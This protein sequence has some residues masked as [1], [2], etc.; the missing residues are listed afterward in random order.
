[1]ERNVVLGVFGFDIIDP[2]AHEAPLYEELIV[3]KVEVIP[4]KRRDLAH[5]KTEAL[6]DLHHRAIRLAQCREDEFELFHS[7]NDGRC[8]RLLPP[9]IRTRAI[10]FTEARAIAEES[11]VL[12]KNDGGILPLSD[13]RKVAMVGGH[14]DVG[15]LSGVGSA[16]VDAPGGSAVQLSAAE[17]TVGP[18]PPVWMP[19]SPLKALARALP[20]A[21]ITYDSGENLTTAV[22]AARAAQV[23]VVFAYQWEGETFDLP[24]LALSAQQ[25]KLIEAVAA[26][27]PHTVVVLES[28]GPVTMLWI[29]KVQAVVEAW[30]PG[31]R[32]GDALARVL[33]GAVDPSG[34]L[35]ITFPREDADLPHP[36]TI[37]SPPGSE[38]NVVG[39]T[40][41]DEFFL[42]SSEGLPAF[43][44][45]YDEGLE[46]GYKWYD[47]Q[48]KPVLFPFGF[49]LSFTTYAYSAPS[50]SAG[51]SSVVS[52]RCQEYR[53]ARRHGDRADIC[54]SSSIGGRT[55]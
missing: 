17:V 13:V 31:I 21:A 12:L 16:Q 15:V 39:V 50:V 49:G 27:N 53:C 32:G 30:Y 48:Q 24:T 2:P 25:N 10:G 47:A 42:R 1:M 19:N 7:Q 29:G 8:R 4:L 52:L 44:V 18:H 43:D 37:P 34:K 38:H 20:G 26:V 5:A 11:I 33:T 6:G 35:A 23:A 9:L 54:V 14:A 3:L 51:D 41:V 36:E 46:V 40:D 22:A 55:A 45:T 28:G